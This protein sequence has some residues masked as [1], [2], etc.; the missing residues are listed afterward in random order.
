MGLETFKTN[1]TTTQQADYLLLLL[2]QRISDAVIYFRPQGAAHICHIK[3][4]R[5]IADIASAL[6]VNEGFDCKK[7]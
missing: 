3:T 6:I 5:D 7:I 4:N 1:I 2:R